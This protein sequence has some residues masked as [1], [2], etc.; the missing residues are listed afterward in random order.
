[1]KGNEDLM[2]FKHISNFNEKEEKIIDAWRNKIY[3]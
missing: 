3:E 2:F 1:L